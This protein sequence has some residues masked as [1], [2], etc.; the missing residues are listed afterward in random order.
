MFGEVSQA[1]GKAGDG[2]IGLAGN[3]TIFLDEIAEMNPGLQ[4][5]VVE[6]LRNR[7]CGSDG[8]GL[9]NARVVCASSVDLQTTAFP[10]GTFAG[11]PDHFGHRVRLLPLRERKQDIPQLCEYLIEKFA[12]NFGRPAPRLSASVLRSFQRWNWLGNIRELENWIARIVI[13]GT[14]EAIGSEFGLPMA[15]GE[16]V[17]ARHRALGMFASRVRR[18]RGRT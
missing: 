6:A 12:Q 10:E 13:F 14:E 2:S 16:G 8:A 15:S 18:R 17:P 9:M 7:H 11:L 5:K 4:R 3:G 1:T